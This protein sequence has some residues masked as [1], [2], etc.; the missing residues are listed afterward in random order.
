MTPTDPTTAPVTPLAT[1][2]PRRRWIGFALLTAAAVLAAVWGYYLWRGPTAPTPPDIDTAHVEPMV[3]DAIQLA[4]DKVVAHPRDPAAWGNLAMVLHAHMFYTH[5]KECYAVAE[6][7]EPRNPMWPYLHG[8]C[9]LFEGEPNDGIDCLRRALVRS[10]E[11]PVVRLHLGELLVEA[12]NL[13][14]A[15]NLF[16]EVYLRDPTEPRARLGLGRVA[17]L[18]GNARAS[19]SHLQ[20][21]L[22][23]TGDNVKAWALLAEAYQELGDEDLSADA[24]KRA[25]PRKEPFVWPDP[26]RDQVAALQTGIMGLGQRAEALYRAGRA[27]EGQKLI[28]ELVARYPESSKA[29]AGLGRIHLFRGLPV[30]AESH[31]REAL[32]MEPELD[33]AR[34]Y[35]AMSLVEQKRYGEA[36]TEYQQVVAKQPD[37][38]DAHLRLGECHYRLGDKLAA[39]NSF[40]NAV[41]YEPNNM[42]AQKNLGAVQFEL[43]KYDEAIKTLEQAAILDPSDSKLANLLKRARA[44]AAARK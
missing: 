32:R 38:A 3:R 43:K 8:L 37:Y 28:E 27:D 13:D 4:R 6:T 18:R 19:L 23:R 44:A 11:E 7:L 1:P 22:A 30:I 39:L 2:S 35:L 9:F 5:A 20:A 15:E 26:Y 33:D 21:C 40:Q 24:R 41:R 31:L 16:R 34:Y 25:V 10:G 42:A 29:R 17:L 36:V 12:G 14:E